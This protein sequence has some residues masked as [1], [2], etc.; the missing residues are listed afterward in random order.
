MW[1]YV[2]SSVL[3]K[4][5]FLLEILALISVGFKVFKPVQFLLQQILEFMWRF[6]YFV[7]FLISVITQ[8]FLGPY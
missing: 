7:I 6:L 5:Y 2:E 1:Y 8:L 4:M 3:R